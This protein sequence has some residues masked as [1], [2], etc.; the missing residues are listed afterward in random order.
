MSTK[1]KTKYFR[2]SAFIYANSKKPHF[3]M[4]DIL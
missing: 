1:N 4:R 3:F 2:I